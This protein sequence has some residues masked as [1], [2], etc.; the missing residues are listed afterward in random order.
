[1]NNYFWDKPLGHLYQFKNKDELCVFL[2]KTQI[3]ADME[4]FSNSD[5]YGISIRLIPDDPEQDP[6][7]I[8][9]DGEYACEH[10]KPEDGE[11]LYQMVYHDPNPYMEIEEQI[12]GTFKNHFGA[13]ILKPEDLTLDERWEFPCNVFIWL[14]QSWDRCGNTE[15]A[16]FQV[17]P[18]GKEL[19]VQQVQ[20]FEDQHM[21][22]QI[23]ELNLRLEWEKQRYD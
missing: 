21:Q 11:R 22:K 16:L 17:T 6:N 13:F 14:E 8:F 18:V 5:I 7:D 1:M 15:I 19:T 2:N 12:A 3:H 4:G 20:E 23:D 9:C 10:I